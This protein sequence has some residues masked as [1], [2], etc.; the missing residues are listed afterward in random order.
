MT[1]AQLPAD[2]DAENLIVSTVLYDFYLFAQTEHLTPEHF[3][4]QCWSQLWPD[5]K[6]RF[7]AGRSWTVNDFPGDIIVEAGIPAGGFQFE[8]AIKRVVEAHALRSGFLLAQQMAKAAIDKDLPELQRILAGASLPMAFDGQRTTAAAA[9]E[10]FIPDIGKPRRIVETGFSDLDSAHFLENG[11]LA[12]LAARPG[13]GKSLIAHQ[14]CDYVARHDPEGTVVLCSPEMSARQVTQRIAQ[15]RA[16]VTRDRAVGDEPA[17]DRLRH[18]SREAAQ[19][20]TNL[21]IIDRSISSVELHAQCRDIAYRHGPVRL[22][23]TDHLRLCADRNSEE[24]HRLGQITF[25]HMQ[26]SRE[27]DCPVLLLCQLNRAVEGREN[28]RPTLS[29]IRDSGEVEESADKVIA[30][31]RDGYYSSDPDARSG[32]AEWAWLKN[33]D[34]NLWYKRTYFN[35]DDGPRFASRQFPTIAERHAETQNPIP[36]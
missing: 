4:Q 30:L 34:G 1:L 8:E 36:F 31:Y 15:A 12:V 19:E 27:F 5:L 23:V 10:L 35:A 24:R 13:M 29:D 17:A 3:L 33:R 22:I 14:L 26:M 21:H 25:R 18:A 11:Y 28:K 2:K 6:Q 9:M 7:A 32:D 20:L 16:G